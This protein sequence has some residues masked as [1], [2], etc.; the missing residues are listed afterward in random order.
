MG[1]QKDGDHGAMPVST[2]S[3][4]IN[5]PDAQPSPG[6]IQHKGGMKKTSYID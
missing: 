5:L 4:F 1:F 2:D 3:V 6:E